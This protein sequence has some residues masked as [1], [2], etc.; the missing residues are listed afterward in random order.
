[1]VKRHDT[2]SCHAEMVKILNT[3][4]RPRLLEFL[5]LRGNESFV[6]WWKRKYLWGHLMGLGMAHVTSGQAVKKRPPNFK[7]LEILLYYVVYVHWCPVISMLFKNFWCCFMLISEKMWK[8][9]KVSFLYSN[10]YVSFKLKWYFFKQRS[11]LISFMVS[12]SVLLFFFVLFCGVLR[13][14]CYEMVSSIVFCSQMS[15]FS[16]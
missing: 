12:C 16:P 8:K 10:Y 15:Y 13:S 2:N 1:M 3:R 9:S 6:H 11:L 5:R 14:S 4:K 7:N